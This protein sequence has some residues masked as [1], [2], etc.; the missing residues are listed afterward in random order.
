MYKP[1]TFEFGQPSTVQLVAI[2]FAEWAACT[3]IF[4]E[5]CSIAMQKNAPN[6]C[7]L[8]TG[9][10]QGAFY[11]SLHSVTMLNV[12][13]QV[14]PIDI[15]VWLGGFWGR[16]RSEQDSSSGPQSRRISPLLPS[17]CFCGAVPSI[18][19]LLP[20]AHGLLPTTGMSLPML[21]KHILLWCLIISINLRENEFVKLPLINPIPVRWQVSSFG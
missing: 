21:M 1:C 10:E 17:F 20:V 19:T 2:G 15:S 3:C 8:V 18:C 9:P 14:G 12:Q 13:N 4:L 5:D 6:P 16:L 7:T 11:E